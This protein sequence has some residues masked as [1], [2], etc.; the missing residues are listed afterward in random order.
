MVK[1]NMEKYNVPLSR[2]GW[3]QLHCARVRNHL[4]SR[5]LNWRTP[6]EKLTGDTPDISMFR[7]HFWEPIEYLDPT[8]NQPL[9]GWK[10]G[11]FLGINWDS[12]DSMTYFVE[13]EK[14]HNEGRNVVLTRSN[15]RSKQDHIPPSGEIDDPQNPR[16]P[17]NEA[18]SDINDGNSSDNQ[19][20]E[21]NDI[22]DNHIEQNQ[23]ILVRQEDNNDIDFDDDMEIIFQDDTFDH[24]QHSA[25]IDENDDL[26]DIMNISE[27]ITNT[28]DAEEEDYEFLRIFKHRWE[29]GILMLTIEL[30][31]GKMFESPFAMI[32]KNRSIEVAT[33]I[34]NSIIEQSRN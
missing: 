1:R 29:S 8:E 17:Q 14:D 12:G 10:K 32:K 24:N 7:F 33:Y 22:I 26:N 6:L 31:S 21:N 13:T 5:K 18:D 15:V 3:C 23:E 25:V 9:S 11:R 19:S 2:H 16:L 28:I 34:K 4:A 30:D 20:I 27:E